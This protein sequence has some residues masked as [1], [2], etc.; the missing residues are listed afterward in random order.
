MT[1]EVVIPGKARQR[2]AGPMADKQE[3]GSR[4]ALS[5]GLLVLSSESTHGGTCRPDLRRLILPFLNRDEGPQ[6]KAGRSK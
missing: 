4:L 5:S 1:E 3:P 6:D 2:E